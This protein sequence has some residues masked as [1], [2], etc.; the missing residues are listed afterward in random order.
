MHDYSIYHGNTLA[1]SSH[2]QWSFFAKHPII[3]ICHYLN[4]QTLVP[5]DFSFFPKIIKENIARQLIASTKEDLGESEQEEV[6]EV[7]TGIL[8]TTGLSRLFFLL[9]LMERNFLERNCRHSRENVTHQWNNNIM[10]WYKL[11]SRCVCFESFNLKSSCYSNTNGSCQRESANMQVCNALHETSNNKIMMKRLNFAYLISGTW[12]L[13]IFKQWI[14]LRV[15]RNEI[16]I[17]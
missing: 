9:T 12:S 7:Q 13:Q 8:W 3:Q 1:S 16:T 2:L 15:F 17:S 14:L 10:I 11:F 5:C 6:C 4:G